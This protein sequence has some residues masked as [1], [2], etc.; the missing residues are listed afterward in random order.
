MVSGDAQVHVT[1]ADAMMFRVR[2]RNE[3]RN[4]S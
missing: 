4:N 3:K 2:H 1:G